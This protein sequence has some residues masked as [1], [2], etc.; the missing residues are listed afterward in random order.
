MD[1]DPQ[2]RPDA[3]DIRETLSYWNDMMKGSDLDVDLGNKNANN[4]NADNE[5]TDNEDTNNENTD[6]KDTDNKDS[7]NV[8]EIKRQFLAAD[9]KAKELPTILQKHSDIMYT[10]KLINT[11][12]IS[13][14]IEGTYFNNYTVLHIYLFSKLY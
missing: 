1:S 14:E 4:E 5:N 12:K 13:S 10:S 11:Q 3:Y 7:D 6:N 2:K 9:K 8:N